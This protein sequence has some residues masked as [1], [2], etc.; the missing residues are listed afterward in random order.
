[1]ADDDIVFSLPDCNS[2]KEYA[3]RI[4]P[5]PLGL[6]RDMR[7]KRAASA[8]E[9][10]EIEREIARRER[11]TSKDSPAP[12]VSADALIEAAKA[13]GNALRAQEAASQAV[14]QAAIAGKPIKALDREHNKACDAVG[15]AQQEVLVLAAM[16]GGYTRDDAEKAV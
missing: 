10:K 8:I 1:M 13:Y 5:M 6:L 9:L 4:R 15:A 16:V 3:Q 12:S 11:R 14:H 2:A 7:Q